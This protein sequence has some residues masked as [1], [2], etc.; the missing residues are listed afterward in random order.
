MCRRLCKCGAVT[1]LGTTGRVLAWSGLC[2]SWFELAH[3]GFVNEKKQ[4]PRQQA[5]FVVDG[6]A[7]VAGSLMGTS[8]IATYIE[9]AAGIREGGRTGI[10][11]LT[12][13]FYFFIA[14]FFVPVLCECPCLPVL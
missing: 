10:T 7:T 5:T 8:P 1:T 4:F 2:T 3:A 6:L 14:L 9:S 11:A 13:A 12:C